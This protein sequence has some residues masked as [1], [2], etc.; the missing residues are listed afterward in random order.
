MVTGQPAGLTEAHKLTASEGHYTLTGQPAVLFFG[1]PLTAGTGTYMLTGESAGLDWGHKIVAQAGSFILT[2]QPAVLGPSNLLS[3]ATGVYIVGRPYASLLDARKLFAS[4]GSF[5]LTGEPAGLLQP[6]MLIPSAGSFSLTGH[7]AVLIYGHDLGATAGS[8]ILTGISASMLGSEP[9][10]IWYSIYANTGI[11]D[12]IN[13]T[14]PIAVVQTVTY[15]TAAL[16]YPGTWRLAVRAGDLYGQEQNLDCAVTI[17]LSSA[18][19]D[20]SNTPVPPVAVRALA[21]AGGVI[22]VEW[23]YPTMV[24]GPKAPT[25]FHVYVGT[26]GTPNYSSPAATASWGSAVA[27]TWVANLNGLANG[28]TYTI[29]VRAYNL[30][31]EEVNTNT[32]SQTAVSVG[33]TAVV[34]LTATAT[35]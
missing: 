15:T 12:P 13:Y 8:Y 31:A 14:T 24:G 34:S 6:F 29:A 23:G 21:R 3:A 25:G 26:G 1:L 2:G 4:A 11:G 32:V 17:T 10:L 27:N 7:S 5:S 35:V 30:T 22:R 19:Y 20:V 18:G 9:G 28:V 33:P 16:T